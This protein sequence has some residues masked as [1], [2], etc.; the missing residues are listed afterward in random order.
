MSKKS[1][2]KEEVPSMSVGGGSI[3][4][5]TSPEVQYASQIKKKIKKK[6]LSRAKPPGQPGAMISDNN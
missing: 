2:V 5:L 3:P 1:Q 4:S 6:I